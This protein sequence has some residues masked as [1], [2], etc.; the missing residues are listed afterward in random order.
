M[1][2]KKKTIAKKQVFCYDELARIRRYR[3]N[4]DICLQEVFSHGEVSNGTL[5]IQG[6]YVALITPF[7]AD[8]SI[9]FS[10]L[11]EL[12]AWQID[13]GTDGIVALG[14]TGESSTMTHEEDDRVAECVLDAVAGRIPVIIGSG[15]NCTDT[16]VMKSRR[17]AGMGA[18]GL[19]VIT[20]YY[21]KAND[22]G[23]IRH[24][25]TVADSVSIP[26][27][28][29]NVPGRTGCA[30]AP[31]VVE[32]LSR[33]PNIGSIKEA[34]GD[35]G[36]VAKIARYIS[37]GF[38]LV[39]GN[40]NMI[41]PVM[42]LGGAGVISVFANLCPAVCKEMTDAWRAGDTARAR[43]LQLHYLNLIDAL[44]IEVNPIPIKEA[45]NLLGMEIGGYRMPLCEMAE[46]NRAR[47][48]QAMEV[49]PCASR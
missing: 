20:P 2:E 4:A 34:S 27:T 33:H 21:N 5:R 41:V 40:D 37:D 14:T 38:A 36:Y 3:A 39:S 25:E 8:G 26:L 45:M 23:M 1:Q 30:L 44:F 29:Y 12:C 46:A 13:Q 11:K 47:L 32:R 6:S 22:T 31:H 28:L 17:Y 48:R 19:L 18:D 42:S 49:I 43:A 15:S 35:I 10:K 24:F 7:H 16:A 9:N